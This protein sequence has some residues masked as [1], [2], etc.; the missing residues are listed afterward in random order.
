M[1]KANGRGVSCITIAVGDTQ[2]HTWKAAAI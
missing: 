2:G 1:V